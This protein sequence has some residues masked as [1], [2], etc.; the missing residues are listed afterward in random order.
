MSVAKIIQPKLHHMSG[1]LFGNWLPNNIV[2]VG[3]YGII[4]NSQFERLGTFVEYGA[5]FDTKEAPGNRSNLEYKDR[6]EVSVNALA[7]AKA[8]HGVGAKVSLKMAARGSFL[9]HLSNS[10]IIRPTNT[11]LF[12]EEVSRVLLGDEIEF[13]EDGVIITEVQQ[14]AKATIVVSDTKQAALDLQTTFKP[15]G[16]AFLAGA[17][18]G[19]KAT[20]SRG[21]VFQFV[22]QN[23]MTAL[24][25]IVRPKI[26]PPSGPG[27][28]A[29]QISAVEQTVE[30]F[31]NL[32]REKRLR[33]SE[34]VITYKQSPMPHTAIRLGQGGQEFLLRMAPLTVDEVV[35]TSTAEIEEEAGDDLTIEE[36]QFHTGYREASG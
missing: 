12:N 22:A 7:D 13:P 5:H 24:L 19:I 10:A 36:Q 18:G 4:R 17:K 1:G 26:A 30:W 29:A 21:S 34:L 32:F 6:L 8:G 11:R 35:A 3:D 2:E 25:R 27:G 9:Y 31:K 33:I 23:D 28:P 20:G 14:A 15:D 16:Q